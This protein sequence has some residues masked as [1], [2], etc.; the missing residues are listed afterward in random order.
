MQLILK[1]RQAKGEQKQMR[2]AQM[3]RVIGWPG[4]KRQLIKYS[5]LSEKRLTKE[6]EKA[7]AEFDFELEKIFSY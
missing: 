3:I 7:K 1:I 5:H 4:L 6:I 2:I